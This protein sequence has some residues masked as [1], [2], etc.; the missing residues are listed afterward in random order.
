MA[1][2]RT[3][4]SSKRNAPAK[5]IQDT[6]TTIKE[7]TGATDEEIK[8]MLK[9]CNNDA[10]EATARLIDSEFRTLRFTLPICK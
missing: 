3:A 9:E 4:D 10:N 7:A 1:P 2:G 8:H 5:K 6:I